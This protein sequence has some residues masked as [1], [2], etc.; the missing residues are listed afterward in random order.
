M[1]I[2]VTFVDQNA[3]DEVLEAAFRENTKLVFGIY[4]NETTFFQGEGYVSS[5]NISAAPDDKI[6]LTAEVAGTGAVTLTVP[7]GDSGS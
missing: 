7:A 5:F 3:S 2:E 4:L 6:S 1:G